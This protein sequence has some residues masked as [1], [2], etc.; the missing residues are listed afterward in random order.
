Y[1]SRH[2]YPSVLA[3]W[4]AIDY[5]IKTG[6]RQFDFMGVGKPNVPYGVRDFKMRFGG[7]VVNYG[8]YIRINN[9]FIYMLAEFGYNILSLMK[10][11]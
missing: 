3:T 4:A 5:A 10:K 2:I 1:R 7:T 8:R 9:K 6:Y 11:V